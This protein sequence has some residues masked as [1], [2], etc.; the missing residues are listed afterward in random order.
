MRILRLIVSNHI[1]RKESLLVEALG[2]S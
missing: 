2:V 1:A